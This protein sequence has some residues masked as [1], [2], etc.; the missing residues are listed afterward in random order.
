[1]LALDSQFPTFAYGWKR[2]P[3]FGYN[4]LTQWLDGGQPFGWFQISSQIRLA[5]GFPF[6]LPV[7]S[8]RTAGW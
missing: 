4:V 5:S 1:M 2:Y 7:E 3:Q 6:T 8:D